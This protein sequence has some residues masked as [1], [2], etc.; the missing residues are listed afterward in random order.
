M[1]VVV[2][3]LSPTSKDLPIVMGPTI[4][5]ILCSVLGKSSCL[6]N[7]HQTKNTCNCSHHVELLGLTSGVKISCKVLKKGLT[8][9]GGM[10]MTVSGE[11]CL[12]WDSGQPAYTDPSV[13]PDE[14][15][16]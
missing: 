1:I 6:L 7:Y 16:R 5:L 14:T 3:S 11:A 8:Y 10:N 13:F 15:I 9:T 12:R 2:F 4:A